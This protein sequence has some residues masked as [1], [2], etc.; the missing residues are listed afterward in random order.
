M[1]LEKKQQIYCRLDYWLG[2]LGIY[3]SSKPGDTECFFLF[4][5]AFQGIEFLFDFLNH[6]FLRKALFQEKLGIRLIEK[7]CVI[8]SA[9]K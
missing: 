6:K 5:F 7:L 9:E 2:E 8:K 1:T 4:L 3:E